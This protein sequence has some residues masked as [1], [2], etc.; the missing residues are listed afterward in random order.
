MTPRDRASS[1][2]PGLTR[3]RFLLAG[4]AAVVAPRVAS[5][6]TPVVAP[7]PNIPRVRIAVSR[8]PKG[9][10]PTGTTHPDHQ[11]LDTLALDAPN[12]WNAAG[13]VLSAITSR[14]TAWDDDEAFELVVRPGA[15]FHDGKPLRADDVRYALERVRNGSG[16]WRHAWRLEH[17][18]RLESVNDLTVRVML[19]RPDVSLTASLAHQAFGILPAGTDPAG[20]TGGSGPFMLDRSD[21]ERW[22]YVRNEHF[23]QIARPRMDEIEVIAVEDDSQRST[24]IARGEID[25]LPNVPLLDIPMLR[26]DPTVYLAGGP[27]NRVCHLQLNLASPALGDTRVRR[28]LSRA[29]DRSRLV[30][31][32]TAG[33]ATPTGLLF[34]AASWVGGEVPDVAAEEPATIRDHLRLLGIPTDLRL[35]LLTNNADATL[36]NTAIVLQEQL[37]S[38]GIALSVDLLQDTDLDDAVRRREFDILASYTEPWRDPHELV[39]PLLASDG[40]RNASGFADE[41][42]DLLIR[43][44][45]LR[46]DRAFRRGRYTRI[47]ERVQE[48]V[49]LIVVFHPHSYDAVTTALQGYTAFPPFTSRGLLSVQP[50]TPAR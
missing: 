14:L 10:D 48:T 43:G 30:E 1:I 47:E 37:A 4:G 22:H 12:R 44:A 42:V 50:A 15:L 6:Q 29:I 18:R 26:E 11:W 39:R 49:P 36:A 24:T 5:A 32:A 41:R 20:V 35:R 7:V 8:L 45:I 19:D 40:V 2:A 25:V 46:Q 9:L 33:Q 38:C 13:D 27:S 31:V 3:R 17:V 28:L 16:A 21:D 23:W 34:P